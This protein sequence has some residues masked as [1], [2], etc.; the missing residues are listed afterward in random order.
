M[1]TTAIKLSN[2]TPDEIYKMDYNQLIG[3][4]RETNRPPGG[5]NTIFQLSQRGYLNR[6][7]K[8]LEIGTSTGITAVELAKTVGCYITAIDI[9]PMSLEEAKKRAELEGVAHLID[10]KVMDAMQTTFEDATFDMVFCGNVTSLIPNREKA[11]KEYI[12]ILKTGG[13]IAASPMYYIN[14]PSSELLEAVSEAIQV[15]IIPWDRQYWMNFFNHE[16]LNTYWNESY[17]FDY[18]ETNTVNEFVGE[19]LKREHL[20]DL[21]EDSFRALSTKYR[22]H[23]IL[24]RDN[25]SIMGY[26]LLLLRKENYIVD[27]ELFT[28]SK[29]RVE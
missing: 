6:N 1:T 9:N 2:L 23:M 20:K 11:F 29:I 12:R 28:S 13:F 16:L 19:I 14:D 27:S 17:A 8:V 3:L 25:L 15:K 10:F 4:V 7:S 22:E 24:F 5:Y 21:S 26:S 18:I